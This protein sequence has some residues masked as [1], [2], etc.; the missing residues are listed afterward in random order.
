[1]SDGVASAATTI[2]D[3][4]SHLEDCMYASVMRWQK[5]SLRLNTSEWVDNGRMGGL[6]ARVEG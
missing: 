1:M 2:W 6:V 3:H 4:I 5:V